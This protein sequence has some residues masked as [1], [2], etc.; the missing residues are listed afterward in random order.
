MV[1]KP[2]KL[3]HVKLVKRNGRTYAYFN[4]GQKRDGKPIYAALGSPASVGFFDRYA[5]LVAGR[6][7]RGMKAYDVA[8]LVNDYLASAT[9]TKLSE[10]TQKNYRNH[11]EKIKGEWGDFRANDLQSADV[12]LA[13]EGGGWGPGTSNMV[14]AVLGAVYRWGRR[15]KGLDVNPTRDVD[16]QEVGAH[17]PWPE[18]VLEAAL[19]ADDA[20]VRL[21]VHL[22]YFTGQR[23]GDVMKMRWGDIR[24]GHVYVK[25][26]KTGKVVEPPLIAE[27]QDELDRTP[28]EGLTII[29]GVKVS[30]LRNRMKAFTRSH[31]AE[32]VPHGLRKNAVIALLEAGCTVPEVAAITG[33]THQVVEHYAA[34]VS[35]RKL[36]KAAIVKFEKARRGT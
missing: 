36:G 13:V 15:N 29:H 30:T 27:L 5:A 4:T 28:R 22:L 8:G 20:V 12:R 11:A 25:Q 1:R 2:P 3:P 7:K 18:D 14:L 21:A 31:G 6:T 9:F 34:K 19:K 17:E 24:D 23:I 10:S 26:Q 16:R 33:Q 32:T 35:R